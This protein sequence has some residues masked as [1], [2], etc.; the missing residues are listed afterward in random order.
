MTMCVADSSALLL[1]A[2]VTTAVAMTMVFNSIARVAVA[3]G[4]LQCGMASC[5]RRSRG[6]PPFIPGR[7]LDV[8]HWLMGAVALQTEED[9]QVEGED[10]PPERQW[11]AG[12]EELVYLLAEHILGIVQR[13]RVAQT[14][15]VRW[16]GRV[17]ESF[18]ARPPAQGPL[19][20][21]W[22]QWL[23]RL[24]EAVEVNEEDE[25]AFMQRKANPGKR[26]TSV[27]SMAPPSPRSQGLSAAGTRTHSLQ[28]ENVAASKGHKRGLCG[29]GPGV[30]VV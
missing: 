30:Y 24:R 4:A 9:G 18:R 27:G 5:W 23:Q 3:L 20:P 25:V 12:L 13:P 14:R 6:G 15:R 21:G 22:R 28:T 11:D 2:R 8:E 26:A 17:C 29:P 16:L 1:S 7:S 19:P 10:T